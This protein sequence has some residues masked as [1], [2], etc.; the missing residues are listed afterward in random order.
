MPIR[1]FTAA[2]D[3]AR[4]ALKG[5]NLAAD[6]RKWL[7]G[8][9]AVTSV[10]S[11]PDG[12]RRADGPKLDA[13]RATV[14]TGKGPFS[15]EGPV[16]CAMAGVDP[17]GGAVLARAD[18]DLLAALKMLRHFYLVREAGA[19]SVWV[20][21]QP[22]QYHAWV[23]DEIEGQTA[24]SARAKLGKRKE[25]YS[26]AD[27]RN[28]G[29][30]VNQSLAWCQKC[31]H[32]LSNPDD[33]VREVVRTWFA[34]GPAAMDGAINTLKDGFKKISDVL[35]SNKLV[36]SDEPVNRNTG[37]RILFQRHARSEWNDFA[38]VDGGGER[39]DVVY[40]Q[41]AALKA[42]GSQSKAWIATVTIIHE[43]SHRILKTDDVVY[44]YAGLQPSDKLT[45][46]LAI[47][48]ADTWGYFAADLNGT[49]PRKARRRVYRQAEE[50][51]R[52][53]AAGGGG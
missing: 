11:E 41:N 38:F 25:V 36:F 45:F 26:K 27:R 52:G 8:A 20:Y 6:Q 2:Y 1:R 28:M 29:D 13:F 34:P 12:P 46:R 53:F 48:N 39:L 16:I 42:W 32:R 30:G 14:K 24:K 50:L 33:E 18:S 21:A 51:E 31:V 43:L 19:Q 4:A 3:R 44:D 23:F 22:Y 7:E 5:D 10:F 17:D 15:G 40:V 37:D 49:L 9:C 47:K 35:R